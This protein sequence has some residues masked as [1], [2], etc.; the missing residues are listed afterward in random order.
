MRCVRDCN[1]NWSLSCRISWEIFAV[2]VVVE[3]LKRRLRHC[4]S[5][6]LPFVCSFFDG[7]RK[8]LRWII[9]AF[10]SFNSR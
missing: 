4:S 10:G 9:D 8:V 2:V 3:V 5:S 7:E 6:F 1:R